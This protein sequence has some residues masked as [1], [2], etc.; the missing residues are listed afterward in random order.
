[1]NLIR[2]GSNRKLSMV[3]RQKLQ[4]LV[5]FTPFVA[6][7][8]LFFAYPMVTSIKYAFSH[9]PIRGILTEL[10]PIGLANFTRA[11]VVDIEFMPNFLLT[12]QTTL[13]RMPLIVVFSMILAIILNRKIRFRGFFRTIFFLPFLLGTGMILSL[14]L[15]VGGGK[16]ETEF[17]RGVV[18]TRDL[19]AL[20]EPSIT[21]AV[22]QVLRLIVLAFWRLG[23]QTLLFLAGLQSIPGTL[24]ES[25]HVDGATEWEN[26]WKIT[27]PMLS[28]TILIVAV[29]TIIDS[30]TDLTNNLLTYI[31]DVMKNQMDFTYASAMSWIFFLFNL[32]VIVLIIVVMQTW[33]ISAG[34][35]KTGKRR[36][37]A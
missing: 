21:G 10:E 6:G 26:F 13:A 25:S 28:P 16:D 22:N 36:G 32:A 17:F 14:L 4:G 3:T 30:F 18:V 2:R 1:M 8:A 31:L 29:Y 11:F 7:F 9:M 5:F 37:K 23:M 20:L 34:E 15:G 24:Y 35:T 33:F 19:A 12:V 27:L